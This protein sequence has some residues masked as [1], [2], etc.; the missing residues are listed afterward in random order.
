MYNLLNTIGCV[1][2]PGE[3]QS[4][5]MFCPICGKENPDGVP[6][7][8][9][10]G[11]QFSA[12]AAP[13]AP[14][15]P[16]PA[17]PAAP[18][19]P[20]APAPAAAP[21]VPPQPVPQAQPQQYAAPAQQYAQPQQQYAAPAPAAPAQPSP[22]LPF[23]HFFKS[24]FTATIKPVTGASD[25]AKNYDHIG[26]GIIISSIVVG[27]LTMFYFL[28]YIIRISILDA[29]PR[30]SSDV[31]LR[32]LRVFGGALFD[33]ALMTFGCAALFLLAGLCVK[34]KWS[35]SRLLSISAMATFAPE[36]VKILNTS[37]FSYSSVEWLTLTLRYFPISSVISAGA[38]ILYIVM[39]YEGI[40][41]ETKLEGNKK[42]WVFILVYIALRFVS[43]YI[44]L[45]Y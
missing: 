40:T 3:R 11:H 27:I 22:I 20:A 8:G 36:L 9:G 24:L 19:A 15:A 17:A 38:T 31:V 34:G 10:C 29:W 14:V 2:A 21:I 4:K 5:I 28:V 32:L 45:I 1:R 30:R 42:G 25:E 23:G 12:P 43:H 44:G 13:V 35:F 41:R 39:L 7:C 37:F 26:N 18:V 33:Y 6:F 16:A